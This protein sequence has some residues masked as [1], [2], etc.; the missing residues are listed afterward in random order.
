MEIRLKQRV[1]GALVITTI[2][3][4]VLPM[5]LDGSARDRARITASIPDAPKIDIK[6]FSVSHVIHSMQV[7]EAASER[8]LPVELPEPT[9]V[10]TSGEKDVFE[11]DQNN[12]PVSWALQLGSFKVRDN[13]TKLRQSLRDA[14]FKSYIQIVKSAEGQVYRVFVGPM[15]NKKELLSFAG[16]IENSFSLKGQIIRYSFTDDVNQ[17]GG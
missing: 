15:L 16:T 3:I 5:L 12:L 4:I 6:E 10:V 2:A 14:D 17:L 13:A 7:M 9:H 11:L 8:R 1:I